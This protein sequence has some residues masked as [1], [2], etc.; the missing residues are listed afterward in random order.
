MLR[1][2]EDG[3]IDTIARGLRNEWL[4]VRDA[5]WDDIERRFVNR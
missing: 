5:T 1:A 2:P 3:L 4:C